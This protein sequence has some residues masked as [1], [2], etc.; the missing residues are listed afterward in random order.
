MIHRP[1]QFERF[2]PRPD[3]PFTEE[4]TGDG[5]AWIAYYAIVAIVGFAIGA[6]WEWL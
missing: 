5:G 4:D 2:D 3:L 6:L 1:Q